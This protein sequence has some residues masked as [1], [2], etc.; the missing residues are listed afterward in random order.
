MTLF[1]IGTLA[2]TTL[3]V[4]FTVEYTKVLKEMLKEEFNDKEE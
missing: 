1:I 2:Y 3:V 4:A